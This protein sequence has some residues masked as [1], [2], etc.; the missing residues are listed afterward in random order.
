MSAAHSDASTASIVV[1]I[2]THQFNAIRTGRETTNRAKGSS[3]LIKTTARTR[4]RKLQPGGMYQE[5]LR[6][7]H[8]E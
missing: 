5:P 3:K 4:K 2:I 6:V 1:V 8:A 7:P